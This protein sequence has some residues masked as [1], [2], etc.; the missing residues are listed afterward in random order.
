[1]ESRIQ[2]MKAGV[3]SGFIVRVSENEDSLYRGPNNKGSTIHG[4]PPVIG[5]PRSEDRHSGPKP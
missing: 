3:I 4:N 2:K 5:A 1:M